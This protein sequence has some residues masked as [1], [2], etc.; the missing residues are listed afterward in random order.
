MKRRGKVMVSSKEAILTAMEHLGKEHSNEMKKSM[1]GLLSNMFEKGML[2]KDAMGLSDG[3][4]ESIYGHTYRLYNTGKYDEASQ[5]FRLLIM[6][7]PTAAKYVLGLAACF[8]MLKEY[9]NAAA[10]YLLVSMVDANSPIPYYH[11][12]DC[13]IH[14]HEPALAILNLEQV[15]ELSGN[16][17]QFSTIKD[18]ARITIDSLKKD[19]TQGQTSPEGV[20]AAEQ[21]NI[22]Q[23]K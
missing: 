18:R 11:A 6:L 5:L 2:P 1:E 20:N 7:D 4:I 21:E 23:K 8:H 10:T 17:E 13:Y 12:S 14:L 9:R 15:V 3:L 16:Q 22:V 19:M